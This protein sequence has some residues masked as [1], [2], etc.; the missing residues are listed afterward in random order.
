MDNINETE[1]LREEL[2]RINHTIQCN[3][4]AREELM[5]ENRLYIKTP[6]MT[7]FILLWVICAFI[8]AITVF[9]IFNNGSLLFDLAIGA[10]ITIGVTLVNML[11][12]FPKVRKMRK[13]DAENKALYAELHVIEE[14]LKA[15][16]S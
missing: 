16:E 8:V 11:V 1:S 9:A 2:R 5:I 6:P 14:K 4:K 10:S 13:I 15:I 3:K 12:Y 7:S